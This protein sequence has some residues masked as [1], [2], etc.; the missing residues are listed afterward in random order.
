MRSFVPAKDV[1]PSDSGRPDAEPGP[2]R[3]KKLFQCIRSLR[4]KAGMVLTP[5]QR[6]AQPVSR[7]IRSLRVKVGMVM[8]PIQQ[9]TQPVTRPLPKETKPI[10]SNRP[11]FDAT[12]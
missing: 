3:A 6:P 11:V 10:A 4:V 8:T 12:D 1:K 7:L 9:R 2:N 5:V